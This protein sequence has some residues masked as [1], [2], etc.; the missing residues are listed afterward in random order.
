[1]KNSDLKSMDVDTW[2]RFDVEGGDPRRWDKLR[3][4]FS[5][6][7]RELLDTT[8]DH[9]NG[10]TVRDEAKEFTGAL[11]DF[12][13]AKLS[14]PGLEA[15]KTAA[16][17]AKTF[18]ERQTQLAVAEKTSQEARST[19]IDNDIKELKITLGATR[20]MIVGDTSEEAILF[21]KQLDSFLSSLR[22]IAPTTT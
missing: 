12:A 13:K 20:A 5:A 7:L 14:K 11:L 1:M 17:I 21:G 3:E 15:E 19:R 2:I 22:E 4:K 6:R 8:V 16:D 10:K 9:R 18:A